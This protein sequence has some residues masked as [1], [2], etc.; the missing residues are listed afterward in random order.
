M[1]HS[2]IFI[3]IS[4]WTS[5][6]DWW[7][8]EDKQKCMEGKMCLEYDYVLPPKRLCPVTSAINKDVR[9]GE[10]QEFLQDWDMQDRYAAVNWSD[11]NTQYL[12]V[13]LEWGCQRPEKKKLHLERVQDEREREHGAWFS[14]SNK[15]N[16]TFKA[17]KMS[18]RVQPI[19]SFVNET[20]AARR[21]H[22]IFAHQILNL[23][24]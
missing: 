21:N 18:S 7:F 19:K 13:F 8:P 11:L 23:K 1:G 17:V 9:E 6:I 14:H 2:I 3:L 12:K 10:E 24:L 4:I 5:H 22:F 20:T 16:E 15:Y